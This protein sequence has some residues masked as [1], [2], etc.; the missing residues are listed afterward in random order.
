MDIKA[1]EVT[2]ATFKI[3]GHV[4][5]WQTNF[6]ANT[7]FSYDILSVYLLRSVQANSELELVVGG[8]SINHGMVF[9]YMETTST[10]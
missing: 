1:H 5:Y 9:L 4:A 6:N 10:K 7:G 8:G 3:E 2:G